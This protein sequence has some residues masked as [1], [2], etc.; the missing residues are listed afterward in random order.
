MSATTSVLII[1][2]GGTIGMVFDPETHFYKP[3][4]FDHLSSQ[5]PELTRFDLQ[6]DTIAFE[7]PIDS[8]DMIPDTWVRLAK[9]IGDN[10]DQYDGFVILHGSDTMSYTSSALSFLLEGLNKPVILTGSVLPIGVSRTDGKENLIT[11]IEIAASK[12][13]QGTP[14]V[15]EV[16]IYFGTKLYRGNRAMKVNAEHFEAF[17]SP[18]YPDLAVAGV[19]LRYNF[20][21]IKKKNESSLVVHSDLD[22]NVAI[23]KLFPGITPTV[24]NAQLSTPSLKAI[25]LETYG[26]GNA[27]SQPWFLDALRTA[28][29][30]G[31]IIL[32]ITQCNRGT[33]EQGRYQA[34]ATLEQIGLISGYDITTEA[35]V[36]KLMFLLGADLDKATVEQRM[37]E[38]I[39]GEISIPASSN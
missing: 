36:T 14:L 12:D 11:A 27:S 2:T 32:N 29:E 8:S 16:A 4:D 7:E 39:C 3:F 18:N 38:S 35:A 6:L 20:D 22:P 26:S 24:I 25:V 15:P 34:S 30:K 31:M 19:H 23:L 9:M 37:Y 17:A 33:V 5:V 13:D 28:T 10:Y 1:Y 21:A